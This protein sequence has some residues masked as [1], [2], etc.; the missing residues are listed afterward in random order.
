M[1]FWGSC[2]EVCVCTFVKILLVLA[3]SY[4]RIAS[5]TLSPSLGRGGCKDRPAFAAFFDGPLRTLRT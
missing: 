1:L 3:T 5:E 4:D 2:G